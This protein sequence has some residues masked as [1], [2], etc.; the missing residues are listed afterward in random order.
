MI[1]KIDLDG[2]IRD[3]ITP[4]C[5][6]YN[7][8]IAKTD[9]DKVYPEDV[10][11]YDVNKSFPLLGD[12]AYDYFFKE[13]SIDV[14]YRDAKPYPDARYVI[15]S[16]RKD[17]HMVILQTYQDGYSNM[18]HALAFL[19]NYGIECDSIFFSDRKELVDGDIM[20]DDNPAFISQHGDYV[21]KVCIR[22]PYNSDFDGADVY[23]DSLGEFYRIFKS[24]SKLF[25]R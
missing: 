20:I 25:I 14:F 22:K 16:L 6:L 4:M 24:C 5:E 21:T 18:S 10:K 2:V 23:V 9:E 11:F 19:K 7:N 13:H 3:I 1:I 12:M 8:N 15:E 17:G